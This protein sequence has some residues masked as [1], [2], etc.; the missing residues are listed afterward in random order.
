MNYNVNMTYAT[1]H[2]FTKINASKMDNSSY[3]F[4]YNTKNTYVAD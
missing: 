1:L 4:M 2:F 3:Y